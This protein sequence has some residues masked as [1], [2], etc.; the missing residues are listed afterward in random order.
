VIFIAS[1]GSLYDNGKGYRITNTDFYDVKNPITLE[2][3]PFYRSVSNTLNLAYNATDLGYFYLLGGTYSP[4]LGKWMKA[5]TQTNL[6][7]TKTSAI[8]EIEGEGA[9]TLK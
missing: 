9:T 6:L 8:S 7:L 1:G 4:A 3:Q 2:D 5:R